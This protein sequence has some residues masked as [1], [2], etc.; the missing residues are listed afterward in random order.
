MEK[1]F[2]LGLALAL[3]FAVVACN[4]AT[5][6][7]SGPIGNGAAPVHG[8]GPVAPDSDP[9]FQ[10][11]HKYSVQVKVQPNGNAVPDGPLA[12]LYPIHVEGEVFVADPEDLNGRVLR[13]VVNQASGLFIDTTLKNINGHY[14]FTAETY[15]S[16]DA[17]SLDAY[18]P[19]DFKG[20]L[21]KAGAPGPFFNQSPEKKFAEVQPTMDSKDWEE[22]I[23]YH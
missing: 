22:A 17:I 15:S 13:M 23:L 21:A 16:L 10:I 6:P 18:I 7:V 1:K 11:I 12:G 3:C 4:A 8:S 19:N 14:T 9:T 2:L 5:T 20:F